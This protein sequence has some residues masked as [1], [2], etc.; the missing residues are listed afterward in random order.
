MDE[1]EQ[2]L[3]WFQS[4]PKSW[5]DSAGDKLQATGLWIWAVIQGDFNDN[6]STGQVVTGTLISMIPFVDQ[7]CDVRDLVA[8]CRNISKD[9]NNTGAWVALALTLVGL[10]PVLGSF[11]KGACKVMFLYLR[12][13]GFNMAGKIA[14]KKAFE[15][16]IGGLNKLLDQP[17]VRKTLS[18][19]RIYNPY[20]YLA[21]QVRKLQAKIKLNQLLTAY[22]KL[23]GVAKAILQRAADWGP[24]SIKQPVQNTI[25]LIA[26]VRNKANDGLKKAIGPLNETLGR[27]ARR[28][29]IEGD[30]AYRAVVDKT[31]PHTFRRIDEATEA[32]LIRQ[33]KPEWA[34]I[35]EKVAFRPLRNLPLS[36][37]DKIRAG[38]PNI[39]K[40]SPN[41]T[42]KRKFN[43]FDNS[44][45]ASEVMPGET[46][47]RVVDP[48]SNDNSYCWMREAEFKALKSKADWRRRF[49][50]WKGWNDN[51]E[52]VTYTVP[53]GAPLKVW[54]GRAATQASEADELIK[55]QGGSVQIVVDPTQ[56]QKEYTGKRQPT[57]WGYTDGEFP[58]DSDAF[59][60][61]PRLT[62]NWYG[63]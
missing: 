15:S 50:V 34:D 43:T 57:G 58:S 32:A 56:L 40:N 33:H 59:I 8:N 35:T 3:A 23:A 51:G 45:R 12:K 46:L 13:A 17:A 61:I 18:V 28:L 39:E 30:K 10:F 41:G 42:L 2:A 48:K 20:R 52:Y 21:E 25:Q 4:A 31:N 44:M 29:D 14:D 55:L 36:A 49:A 60:G 27:L 1:L 22:D 37:H 16:A 54:E 38:W 6:Q 5:L 53:P 9:S 47:Y 19:L 24:A 63:N 26:D 62:H 7:I 11:A